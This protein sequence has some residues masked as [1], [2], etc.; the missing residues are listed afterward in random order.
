MKYGKALAD[1]LD[2]LPE[3]WRQ[4]AIEYRK[5]KKVIN[6]VANELKDLGLTSEVLKE[7]LQ[8]P[9]ATSAGAAAGPSSPPEPPAS[10]VPASG[11]TLR[12][13]DQEPAGS[14]S[15][16]EK[17]AGSEARI[18][19]VLD[20]VEG[21]VE[22]EEEEPRM[23]EKAKGKQKAVRK[24][25][26]RASYE[27]GGT[28]A[29][30]EPRIHLVFSSCSSESYSE[31]DDGR[32]HRAAS[33]L[34][35]DDVLDGTSASPA[36]FLFKRHARKRSA[37]S[38]KSV[39]SPK[40]QVLELASSEG[41]DDDAG[42]DDQDDSAP[43]SLA[44][45]AGSSSGP[46]T[47]DPSSIPP[48][49]DA[50]EVT[51]SSGSVAEEIDSGDGVEFEGAG[52]QANEL[53]KRMY[54]VG[55]RWSED[56]GE[57][58]ASIVEL[59]PDADEASAV[60]ATDPPAQDTPRVLHRA[61]SQE[62]LRAS[63]TPLRS[64]LLESLKTLEL[65]AEGRA[66]EKAERRGEQ[67]D[68]ADDEG[69]APSP[70]AAP[71]R[72]KR[73]PHQHRREVFIPLNS[74]TEFLTL[75]ASALNSLATLQLAQKRQFT[76]AVQL[77]AREVSAVSSPSRPKSDLYIW[78]EIFSLWVEAAIF[79]SSR[80]R[81]RGERSIDEVD[82]KLEWF[83]DQVAKRK[84]AKRMR[85]KE[86]RVALEK[87][88]ALNVE[89]LDLKKF[90]VA[91]EEAARKILKKHDKRTALTAS[92]RFPKFIASEDSTSMIST[93]LMLNG[94]DGQPRPILT[95]PGFPSLPHVLLSTFT[96]TLLPIIPQLEDYECSIC[97]DVAFKP[98]RLNCGHKFCVRCLV[99]MQKRG[100]DNCPQCRKAVV[101]RANASNLDN[102]LQKFL[103][104]WF[105]HE[106]RDKERNN[107]KEAAREELEEMGLAERK[108]VVM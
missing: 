69:D 27:L 18:E 71:R 54:G 12:W 5:L 74:D 28:T 10:A 86:S 8:Q 23:S 38:R 48:T 98:I 45:E 95:L 60:P 107:A 88:I 76:E 42:A 49:E 32:S 16:D 40:S 66:Q 59:D 89:L 22:A 99:K 72:R 21:V 9:G 61:L 25:R 41:D 50:T 15:D 4:Q 2:S 87:F 11:G 6:R 79:E 56:D 67:A 102:E 57:G 103:E 24:R 14:G 19:E 47:D 75:L 68:Q 30:P 46:S 91:N 31:S 13:A 100:Q 65:K 51:E 81:D 93:E 1:Q 43:A 92:L 39:K 104:R 108:C 44:V 97:G 7:L 52:P 36:N 64:E 26:V 82:K 55:R 35:D 90:Q 20:E 17:N 3:E 77:L 78:R 84:L 62:T 34:D 58:D 85:H 70:R 101:L 83:V 94:D 33:D 80:E 105:P 53:L 37:G 29:N 106:V 96:T 73:R 63:G